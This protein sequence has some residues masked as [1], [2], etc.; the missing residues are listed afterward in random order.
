VR[1]KNLDVTLLIFDFTCWLNSGE[2]ISTISMP[3]VHVEAAA[4]VPPWQNDYPL[5][6]TSAYPP[7]DTYTLTIQSSTI[8][9]SSTQIQILVAAGTPGLSYVVSAVA[10]SS[11]TQSRHKQIDCIVTIEM[12]LNFEL[13]S[14]SPGGPT[15]IVREID[16]A[17]PLTGGP[18][19]SS[20]TIGLAT[21]LAIN[22]GG[23]GGITGNAALDSLSA[24]AGA[25]IGTLQ[26]SGSGLWSVAAPAPPTNQT[27]TLSGDVTGSGAV[28]ITTTLATVNATVGTFQGLTVNA[29][30]LVTGA[31]NQSYLTTNQAITI[32]GDATGTGTTAIPIT[33][34]NTAV[35]PGSYTNTSLT[36]DQKGRITAASSGVGGAAAV[37]VSDT[38]PATPAQGNQWWDSV[39][40]QLY[41]YVNDGTSS[42]WVAATNVPLAPNVILPLTANA[43]LVGNGSNPVVAS[44]ITSDNGATL[45]VSTNQVI[46]NAVTSPP[47]HALVINNAA[48]T[49]Q[50]STTPLI[51]AASEAGG[52]GVLIDIYSPSASANLTARKARGTAAAPTAVQ[53]ADTLS[54]II[55]TGYGAS[56]YGNATTLAVKAS[57][58]WSN[59]AQGSFFAFS[60][61]TPGTTSIVQRATINQGVVIGNPAVDPG[62][63]GLVLN[64]TATA[65]VNANGCIFWGLAEDAS[66]QQPILLLDSY[67]ST[68]HPQLISRQSRGTAAAP[69]AS[70]A[71]D[72]IL[73]LSGQN[74]GTSA[75]QTTGS[76]NVVALE[77]ATNAARGTGVQ[78]RTTPS[79]TA[80]EAA[81]GQ[82]NN[83]LFLPGTGSTPPAGGVG[84]DMGFGTVNVAGS[85]YINGQNIGA[86]HLPGTATND[87]A[88][89][90]Q[91]GEVI[92]TTNSF[93]LVANTLANMCTISL[94]PGDWD[95]SGEAWGIGSSNSQFKAAINTVSATFP[96]SPAIGTSL[97]AITD[98]GLGDCI[99]ALCPCR[100]SLSAT[101][102]V[103]L[104]VMST[105]AETG[106]G[107]LFARRAR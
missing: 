15:S 39:G 65:P 70:Q 28:A 85:Y 38:P 50:A 54:N 33:L 61:N 55:T 24:A 11:A 72:T 34:S 16:T 67:G 64:A 9:S 66:P 76:I 47:S 49:P 80:A 21:P 44:A 87:N 52:N 4:P 90:G 10:T 46:G 12:P 27:I 100:I 13:L 83:G 77:T 82:F 99:M 102:T 58:N 14:G 59:T 60:T 95:V 75:Y 107:K 25:T 68:K 48:S 17:A 63:G 79:G 26:R 22:Y 69:S 8:A 2:T 105:V 92:S 53:A 35:A 106:A 97:A 98:T 43:V 37:V 30:G 62:Q 1:K 18:I 57:E 101:T 94:T 88:A 51:W 6:N 5:D 84:G 19:T 89:A 73:E 103:Y 29:K 71:G 32:S 42:Q 31:T 7:S 81:A 45:R 36:V 93:A 91:V 41:V 23:T 20:G 56:A 40:G 74:F 3:S 96:G 78:I 86:G 104:V